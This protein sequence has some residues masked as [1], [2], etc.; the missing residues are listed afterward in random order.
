M[1]ELIN[2]VKTK[3]EIKGEVQVAKVYPE[4]EN[5]TVTPAK[6]IQSFNHPDSYG[7]DNV[8][9]KEIDCETLN[10]IPKKEGQAFDGMYD[11]VNV[12]AIDCETLNITP[13][14]ENQSFDG[15]YDKVNVNAIVGDTLNIKPIATAQTFNGLYETVNV[16]TI[17]TEEVTIDPDFSTQDTVE[18]TATNGKY[19][20]KVTVNKDENLVPENILEGKVVCGIEGIGRNGIDTSDATA[21]AEDIAKD[22]TAYVNGEKVI[23][24]MEVNDNDVKLK[25]STTASIPTLLSL[26]KTIDFSNVDLSKMTDAEKIVSGSGVIKIKNLD[27][28]NVTRAYGICKDCSSLEEIEFKNTKNVTTW[29]R[30]FYNCRSL[31]NIIGLDTSSAT[32][33]DYMF[34][35]SMSNED[36]LIAIPEM[37]LSNVTDSS[38][39]FYGRKKLIDVPAFNMPNLLTFSNMFTNCTSLSDNSL[40]NIMA[41]A[42][43]ITNPTN[44]KSL[45]GLGLT[46]DQVTRCQSL[47]NWQA[48]LDAGWVTGY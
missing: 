28:K 39:M 3:H 44:I 26:I 5:L 9:V 16:G 46:S 35:Y 47:S 8:V 18:V 19:I 10:V 11:K 21:T 2:K 6:T 30:A 34:Y 36:T 4:L 22:K 42:I 15:M 27:L 29:I 33:T 12:K 41:T 48:L 14:Q 31:K 43:T 38:Y 32:R 24:T 40:N 7:Y 45:K 23:G 1:S 17:N 25:S 13:K 37:E 20:K